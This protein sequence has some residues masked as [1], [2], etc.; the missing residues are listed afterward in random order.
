MARTVRH[1]IA[2]PLSVFLTS[3]TLGVMDVEQKHY[4]AVPGPDETNYYRIR[5]NAHSIISDS[6]YK[7]GWFPASSVDAAFGDIS[8]EGAVNAHLTKEKVRGLIDKAVVKTTRNFLE[9]AQKKDAKPEDL[10][11]LLQARKDVL[12][13]PLEGSIPGAMFLEYNPGSGLE[14]HHSDEKQ[15]YV[16]SANPDAVIQNIENQTAN[17]N[18]IRDVNRLA[19]LV[20]AGVQRESLETSAAKAV[21]DKTIKLL[22]AQIEVALASANQEDVDKT[23]LMAEIESLT[24][25]VRGLME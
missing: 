10:I 2:F 16:L 18:T 20:Q 14:F 13:Y 12:S 11:R 24:G 7:A 6:K 8:K 25:L 19:S 4:I 3:C 22:L 15:I 5:V 9:E 1:L 17:S 21:N 23:Q